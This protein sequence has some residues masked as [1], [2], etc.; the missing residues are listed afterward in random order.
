MDKE[1]DRMTALVHDLL[2]LSRIDNRQIQLNLAE[3][4]M[5]ALVDEVLEAQ[6]IHIDKNGHKLVYKVDETQEYYIYGDST[7][8]KQ[9]LH[10]IMSNAIKYSIDPG[11]IT[12]SLR[13]EK[14][15]IIVEVADTGI[16]IPASDL[17]RIFERFYRVDKA[18][19]RKL[20]GTGLGLSIAKELV[21]LHGGNIRIDSEIGKGTVVTLNFL[22][23]D[24]PLNN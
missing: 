7:R 24:A 15:R 8:I 19:S 18:R 16:G 1:T 21:E 14:A 5:K 12:V 4:D 10:N 9:V 17:A 2:E 11:T 3:I 20:G 6:I 22:D 13:K 23:Y